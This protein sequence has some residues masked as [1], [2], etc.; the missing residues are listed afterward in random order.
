MVGRRYLSLQPL[1][2]EE[3]PHHPDLLPATS[4]SSPALSAFLRAVFTEACAE[5]FESGFSA[6]GKWSP[7]QGRVAI[8]ALAGGEADVP[9]VVEQ[10]KKT[11]GKETWFARRSTHDE[12][13]V[14]YAEL[15]R[16]LTTDHSWYEYLYTPDLY[17]GNMLLEWD[18]RGLKDATNTFKADL[19]IDDVEMRSESACVRIQR[20][21]TD[22]S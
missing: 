2:L 9:V 13:Q 11:S 18:S 4:P 8:P 22:F 10:R 7:E 6:Q 14:R 3:L 15:D 1:R 5:N 12:S 16:L 20:P 21:D 17:D 19:A